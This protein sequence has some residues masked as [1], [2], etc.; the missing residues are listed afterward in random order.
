MPQKFRQRGKKK[1]KK[2]K[3]D[4]QAAAVEEPAWTIDRGHGE[5]KAV[6]EEREGFDG[7]DED[8]AAAPGEHIPIQEADL[9]GGSNNVDDVAPFG[10]VS[11]ELKG[12]LKDA[13]ASLHQMQT[14]RSEDW[15]TEEDDD[16][17]EQSEQASLLRLAMLREMNGQELACA[18]DGEAS[19][20]L[21]AIIAGLDGRRLRI[22]ADRMSGR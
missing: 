15:E 17:Q 21:E 18:T 22:L 4:Q 7:G 11:P 2:A 1:S 20:A 19:I 5:E 13:L 16:G 3:E 14:K 9:A 6:E 8:G 12:Y 10:F